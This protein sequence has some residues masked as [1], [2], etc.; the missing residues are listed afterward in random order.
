MEKTEQFSANIIAKM[1]AQNYKFK[2]K[3]SFKETTKQT[4]TNSNRQ[5]PP[6]GNAN[7]T[8]L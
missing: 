5:V 3:P 4:A 1:N 8:T 6:I 2:K 7:A